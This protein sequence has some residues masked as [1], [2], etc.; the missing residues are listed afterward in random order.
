MFNV[1]FLNIGVTRACL[2]DVGK[3]PARRE[4]L[5]VRAGNRGGEIA[6]KRCVG[7]GSRGHVVGWLQRRSLDTSASVREQ[8]E[9][10]GI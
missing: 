2:N 8:K 5:C 9:K 10:M 1:D 6:W 4:I 3:V 7:I